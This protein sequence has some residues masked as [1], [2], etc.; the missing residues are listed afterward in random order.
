MSGADLLVT[1]SRP[2]ALSRLGLDFGSLHR[3]F[4]GLC[5]LQIV[6][7]PS[8]DDDLPGHDLSFQAAAG[9]IVDPPR[10][11]FSLLADL[12]GAERAATEA[13][14]LLLHRQRTG[15]ALARRVS[16]AE[17][18]ESLAAPRELCKPDGPLGGGLPGY[19]IYPAKDGWV[20]LAALEPR[21]VERLAA[22]L[23]IPSVTTARLRKIFKGKTA[24]QW[25]A[26]GRRHGI[27]V[28]KIRA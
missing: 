4:P 22:T 6:G 12:M 8:P 11:P 14:A 20:A 10:L 19:G 28:T 15:E 5:Q 21:F 2:G 27:P 13:L 1:A 9:L 3:R 23:K 7:F 26:W 17:A 24:A 25:Q 16:L 18:A